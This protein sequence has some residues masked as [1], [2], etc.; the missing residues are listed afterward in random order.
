MNQCAADV[1]HEPDGPEHQQYDENGPQHL[2][3]SRAAGPRC[4]ARFHDCAPPW[5]AA[6][7]AGLK[8]MGCAIPGKRRHRR[9]TCSC[10][11]LHPEVTAM[12]EVF[13]EFA[14]PVVGKDGTV[15]IARACG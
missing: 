15:Y 11:G 4:G 10:R 6:A 13:V 9:R 1:C 5:T 12:P 8:S 2:H 14:D 7:S 3:T